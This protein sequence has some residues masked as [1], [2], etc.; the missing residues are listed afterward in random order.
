[1]ISPIVAV[2][3]L[4]YTTLTLFQP[5]LIPFPNPRLFHASMFKSKEGC[6]QPIQLQKEHNPA[7]SE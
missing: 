7:Y 3:L 4:M 1:M 6:K 2:P 5:L